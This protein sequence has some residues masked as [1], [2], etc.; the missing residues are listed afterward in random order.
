MKKNNR[1]IKEDIGGSFRVHVYEMMV[2]GRHGATVC[3]E[4]EL[5]FE[6]YAKSL[7]RKS[8]I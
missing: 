8:R 7:T 5:K 6:R 3:I 4:N 2:S 1:L